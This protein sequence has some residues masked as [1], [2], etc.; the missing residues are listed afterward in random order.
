MR[1]LISPYSQKLRNGSNNHPKNYPH[2]AQLIRLLKLNGHNIVQIGIEGETKL[3]EECLFNL[4]FSELKRLLNEVDTFIAVDNFFPHFANHYK[5]YGIVIFGQS[6]PNIF[7][8]RQN[9]NL[10]KDRKYLRADQFGIWESARY[11][12]DAFLQPEEILHALSTMK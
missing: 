2:W 6:D 11:D 9:I 12:V 5:K 8:Y 3:T 4:P 10:L 1:I 7:G